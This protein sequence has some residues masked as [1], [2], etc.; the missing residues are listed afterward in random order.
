MKNTN[1]PSSR[2]ALI[3]GCTGYRRHSK[4]YTIGEGAMAIAEQLRVNYDGT[5]NFDVQLVTD[6]SPYKMPYQNEEELKCIIETFLAEGKKEETG[7]FYFIGHGKGNEMFDKASLW[8]CGSEQM[9]YD[10]EIKMQWLLE[11]IQKSG[12]GNI[13]VMLDCCFSGSFG[14]DFKEPLRDGVCILTACSADQ[15][16]VGLMANHY[17]QYSLFTGFVKEAL[18]GKAAD[19]ITGVISFSSVY[20]YVCQ[21]LRKKQAPV[22]RCNMSRYVPLKQHKVSYDQETLEVIHNFFR[23]N[24]TDQ[25]PN[26]SGWLRAYTRRYV[27]GPIDQERFD[28][29]LPFLMSHGFVIEKCGT[30]NFCSEPQPFY[31]LSSKGRRLW[32]MVEL[33]YYLMRTE[34]N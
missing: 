9:A 1:N 6:Q 14:A 18:E 12:F 34:H 26:G 13:F 27:L 20:N 23:L 22:L 10:I 19:S 16:A 21:N 28:R 2:K 25:W 33:E 4:I 15:P 5:P 11:R 3:I 29:A 24:D 17:T 32:D 8:F 30:N 7:V 31:M